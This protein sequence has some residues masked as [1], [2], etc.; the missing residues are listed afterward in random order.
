MRAIVIDRFGTSDV[1][2]MTDLP[3]PVP[4]PRQVLVR[5]LASSVNPSDTLKRQGYGRAMLRFIPGTRF[6]WL[7]GSDVAGIVE[8]VGAR[9]TRWRAGD[10]VFAAPGLPRQHAFAEYVLVD[11]REAA[12][13]PR[14]ITFEQ[15]A[16]L[17]YVA[18]T[19]W[20]ALS[21]AGIR[22]NG[23]RGRRALVAGGSGGVGTFAI[24]LL[25]AWGWWV[26]AT[27]S[28]A[29]LELVCRLGADR[30]IDY[31]GEDFATELA[32]LDLVLDTVG[33]KLAGHEARAIS[34]LRAGGAYVTIS[35]PVLSLL[36][37]HGVVLGG[38]RA[39]ASG[40]RL[41]HRY[42][43][44]TYHRGFFRADARA[45]AHVAECVEAGTISPVIDRVF[46][47]AQI[48][49]AQAYVETGRARG[50]VALSI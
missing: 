22:P 44:I 50:K 33:S 20:A 36:D 6:P 5:N 30:A 13:K 48:A 40:L 46:P 8:R 38:I 29:N 18:L 7:M 31:R 17:P 43:H 26:A 4:G 41:K 3:V 23:G 39:I 2:R 34:V 15:A 35:H 11:E 32:D 12:R 1:L 21:G 42:A 37:E 28:T 16:S 47:L 19:T 45:L 27:S 10:E 9:V 25:K 14:N 49:A 24:Q